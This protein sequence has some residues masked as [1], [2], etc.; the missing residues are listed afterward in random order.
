MFV[1][2]D[3][4]FKLYM[5]LLCVLFCLYRIFHF[6][7]RTTAKVFM[8]IIVLIRPCCFNYLRVLKCHHN[9]ENI[10]HRVQNEWM[11][12]SLLVNK[13][14]LLAALLLAYDNA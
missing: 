11:H 1:I 7:Y 13:E 10:L 6:M 8:K 2:Y 9:F 3:S 4:F 14:E 12:P 5:P